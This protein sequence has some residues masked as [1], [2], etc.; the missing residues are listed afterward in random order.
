ME[1]AQTLPLARQAVEVRDGRVLDRRPRDRRPHG[2]RARR[3]AGRAGRRRRRER[4]RRGG[5][6]G[7]GARPGGHPGRGRL[8]PAR[9]RA[10]LGGGGEGVRPSE[11]SGWRESSRSS[12]RSS[13]GADGGAMSKALES[14]ADEL[15]ELIA[16]NFGGD[17]STA[18]QHQVR[19]LVGKQLQESRQDLLRQFSAADGHNPLADFKAS[20][21]RE[22]K[23]SADVG[24]GLTERLGKLEAE[25]A[26]LR[27]ASAAHE[28][29]EAERERG[30]GK[31]HD[32]E[33]RAFDLI[34]Q[35]ADAPRRRRAPRGQ[36]AVRVGR[37]A[38]RHRDRARRGLDGRQGPDR[39]RHEGRAPVAERGVA[40][41][42]RGDE[43]A[44]RRLRDP[45]RRV[46]REAARRRPSRSASTRATRC[47]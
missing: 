44:R 24:R 40:R 34:E 30:A 6:R 9:V 27:D 45:A 12:S 46:R 2:R 7:A 29:L 37:Q 10:R 20:V 3:V 17:R 4:S 19:E 15:T 42:R 16:R 31:G 33:Q 28:Q 35:M 32:F 43:G 21:V 13:S 41:A 14:H 25:I 22:I 1:A 38:R 5:D 23:P 47:S 8:R 18:V 26:R 11:P 39:A 36:R